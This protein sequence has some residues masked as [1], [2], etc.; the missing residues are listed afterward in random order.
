MPTTTTSSSSSAS[1]EGSTLR[2]LVTTDNHLGYLERDPR[3]GEDSFTTFEEVLRIARLQEPVVDAMLLG[4][5][6]F[7]DN[8]PSLSCLVRVSA[9]LRKYV[10][11]DRTIEMELLSDPAVNFPTHAVPVANFQDP[12]LNIA[13]PV[14][15]IHGNHDDPVGGTSAIDVLS[16]NACLNY[17]G[18]A[19]SLE[20][21]H[22]YPVLLRKGKTHVALYGLGHVRDERLLRCFKLK[23]VHFVPPP[24]LETTGASAEGGP[25]AT[26]ETTWFRLLIVHQNR[27]GRTPPTA[28]A[29]S[30]DS[31]GRRRGGGLQPHSL[32]PYLAGAGMDLVIWGNE[33]MQE[34]VPQTVHGYDIIQPGSTIRTALPAQ[35]DSPPKQCGILEIRNS[36]YRLT[37]ITLRSV[38]PFVRRVLSMQQAFPRCRTLEA[39]EGAL[40]EVVNDMVGE[41]E[42]DL[43]T[44]IPSDILAF[45]PNLKF[46][47]LSLAVDFTDSSSTPFPQPNYYRLG[48]E[49]MDVVANPQDMVKPLK[50]PHSVLSSSL[51]SG[52]EGT[53]NS[54]TVVPVFP[55]LHTSDIRA[56]IAEVF[57]THSKDACGLLSEVEVSAAVYAFAEKGE[58]TAID[59]RIV[60]LLSSAQKSA[61]RRLTG[62]KVSTSSNSD[63]ANNGAEDGPPSGL[64]GEDAVLNADAIAAVVARHKQEVNRR[65]AEA[66]QHEE[67]EREV[68]ARRREALLEDE[69][70]EEGGN[71]AKKGRLNNNNNN[72]NSNN[73]NNN[74][75]A[76]KREEEL[77]DSDDNVEADEAVAWS[78]RSE[79]LNRLFDSPHP[80]PQQE[81][82]LV[83]PLLSRTSSHMMMRSSTTTTT[84]AAIPRARNQGTN[85]HNKEEVAEEDGGRESS[86]DSLDELLFASRRLVPAEALVEQAQA[87]A[88]HFQEGLIERPGDGLTAS[89]GS[90]RRRSTPHGSGAGAASSAQDVVEIDVDEDDEH[91]VGSRRRAG[92]GGG[93]AGG[94]D[95]RSRRLKSGNNN[96]NAAVVAAATK[97]RRVAEKSA[98]R[99]GAEAGA[100][101]G[102]AGFALPLYMPGGGGDQKGDDEA[103]LNAEGKEALDFLSAWASQT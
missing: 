99:G 25:P 18:H 73:S 2:F 74:D 37:P 90:K 14:F 80:Q 102:V 22:V 40:R 34:M 41:A 1:L 19:H 43:V 45:H 3:R 48:Q 36:M 87:T 66:L 78:R 86:K 67:A 52:A 20:E 9:L 17:F 49:Y 26:T 47:L 91:D 53:A 96:N 65:Y 101:A 64:F 31:G 4:G 44:Q 39:V 68:R 6:L 88:F 35:Y 12:N 97:K 51:A 93:T 85:N 62:R 30:A 58:R 61:Y 79:K 63:N 32:E 23:K 24:P 92:K 29:E 56:K 72:H 83:D 71:A 98:K 55:T 28:A 60:Q 38:R 57:N 70:E 95:G 5:D 7:H 77:D 46:P 33:H 69:D 15:A 94:G 11:G 13:L 54:D 89:A 10:M 42:R 82:H 103:Y 59:E 50:R 100:V 76:V 21:I 81:Q 84:A 8:K 16:T 27:G 75:I